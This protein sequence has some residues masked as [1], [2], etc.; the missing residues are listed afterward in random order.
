MPISLE[1]ELYRA[2][3]LT[4]EE[5][6]FMLP[7]DT[8]DARQQAAKPSARASI[9]FAGPFAGNLVVTAYGDLLPMI[10][11]NML[12]Q[13]TPPAQNEQLDALREIS[14][15]VCGNLL[16]G[17][18]GAEAIFHISPPAVVSPVGPAFQGEKTAE[19][20]IGLQEGR[21]H[22]TLVLVGYKPNE[23]QTA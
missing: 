11:A 3:I 2:A 5:L 6:S 7:A 23:E 20:E 22:F 16:P 15:V 14:N 9:S 21:F 19:V 18:A 4:F 12:G 1:R 10:C 13:D 17:L 8:L